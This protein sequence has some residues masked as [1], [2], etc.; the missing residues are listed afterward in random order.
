MYLCKGSCD[1]YRGT[2]Q[3]ASLYAA[4]NGQ[5][6]IAVPVFAHK[7][8]CTVSASGGAGSSGDGG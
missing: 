2:L 1:S 8:G 5:P 7:A 3:N 4:Q 6:P